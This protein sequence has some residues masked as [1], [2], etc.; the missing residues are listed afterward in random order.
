MSTKICK[1]CKKDKDGLLFSK[2]KE[3]KDGLHIYC[4]E[5]KNKMD[6]ESYHRNK[7]KRS[8]YTKKLKLENLEYAERSRNSVRKWLKDNPKY[9]TEWYRNKRKTD[10][11]YRILGNIRTRIL[12]AIKTNGKG[13]KTI[14]LLGCTI[15]QFKQHI[16]QQFKEGMSWDNY[17]RKGW[18][19][20][21]IK[22]CS[23]F[24]LS[25]FEQQKQCFHY[26]N[27]QPLWWDE[28]LIKSAKYE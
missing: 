24:D 12:I 20:D 4:K 26:T 8:A 27:I 23:L 22:P 19:M 7:E 11:H 16:E 1:L 10:I 5:C 21:H 13:A 17:G 6:L 14:E 28:N 18:H 2:R 15:E 25:I 9:I 3:N